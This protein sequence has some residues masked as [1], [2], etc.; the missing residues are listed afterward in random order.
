MIS[1]SKRYKRS[2]RFIS[3]LLLQFSF[4]EILNIK[5]GTENFHWVSK[6]RL[7]RLELWIERSF[8]PIT[9]FHE[10]GNPLLKRNFPR[11]R[12]KV[13]IAIHRF[14][15]K[16]RLGMSRMTKNLQLSSLYQWNL[17]QSHPPGALF[18]KL[19][20]KKVLQ[21]NRLLKKLHSDGLGVHNNH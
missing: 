5:D 18:R 19:L 15:F 7:I 20:K 11:K 16:N 21:N 2:G 17:L 3:N 9:L 12:W 6:D 8:L 1:L 14:C 13:C 10:K 4:D